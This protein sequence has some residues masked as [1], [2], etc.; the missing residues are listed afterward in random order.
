[1]RGRAAKLLYFYAFYKFKWSLLGW[2]VCCRS[3][4]YGYIIDSDLGEWNGSNTKFALGIDGGF[5]TQ[6]RRGGSAYGKNL[7]TGVLS[8]DAGRF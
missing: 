8:G 7:G 5:F 2:R 6:R 3:A 1:M 4:A